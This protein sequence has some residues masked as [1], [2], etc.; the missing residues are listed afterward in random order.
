MDFGAGNTLLNC[1]ALMCP[2]PETQPLLL[3]G[4]LV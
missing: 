4:D 3:K 1:P 2:I